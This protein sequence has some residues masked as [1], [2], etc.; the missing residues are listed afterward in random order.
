MVAI[1]LTREQGTPSLGVY[2]GLTLKTQQSPWRVEVV[3]GTTDELLRS[4]VPALLRIRLDDND[5]PSVAPWAWSSGIGHAV[6][7]YG[8][9]P[10]GQIDIGDPAMG[11]VQWTRR[12]LNDR[13][14]GE[15]LRLVRR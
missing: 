8:V 11:R 10:D 3:R 7:C 14:R 2:R 1:C 5:R 9:R 12:E 13:W 6:V 4:G 15:G